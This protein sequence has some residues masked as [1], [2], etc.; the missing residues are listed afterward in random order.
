V[1]AEIEVAHLHEKTD[2]LY[3]SMLAR[4]AKLEKLIQPGRV[5]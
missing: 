4:L 3:E 1:K 2:R 5:A